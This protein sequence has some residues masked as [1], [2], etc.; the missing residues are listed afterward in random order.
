MTALLDQVTNVIKKLEPEKELYIELL[1]VLNN[2]KTQLER[3]QSSFVSTMGAK[4]NLEI[5][6][7]KKGED[8]EVETV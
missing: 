1:Q 6:H 2:L 7:I 4:G 8:N 3:Q 5:K